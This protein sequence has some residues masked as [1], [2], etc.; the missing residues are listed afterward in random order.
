MQV[1]KRDGTITDYDRM[2]IVVAIEKA[3]NEVE[4]NERASEKEIDSFWVALNKI[5]KDIK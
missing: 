4:E 1:V 5:I 2:K 3:N